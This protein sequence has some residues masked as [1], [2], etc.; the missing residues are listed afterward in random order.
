MIVDVHSVNMLG[1]RE[2]Q[3]TASARVGAAQD[4]EPAVMYFHDPADDRE[5]K[6]GAVGSL[7]VG[8]PITLP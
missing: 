2:M 3:N 4:L 7:L 1:A 6:P 8:A 5:A